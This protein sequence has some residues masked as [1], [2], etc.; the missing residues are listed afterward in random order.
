MNICMNVCVLSFYD[1]SIVYKL[2][3]NITY[4]LT[5]SIGTCHWTEGASCFS[6]IGKELKEIMSKKGYKSIED[7]RGKLKPYTKHNN[8][9]TRKT[10]TF[11]EKNEN[12]KEKN[13][14]SLVSS[15]GDALRFLQLIIGLLV[16]VI[17]YLIA[18]K[19][20]ILVPLV[21]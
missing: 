19:N 9:H 14:N 8:T 1:L 3:L 20:G 12:Y 17:A 2:L 18:D 16:L 4:S 6:R 15:P 13:A 11:S 10:V 21:F 7:F 5:N